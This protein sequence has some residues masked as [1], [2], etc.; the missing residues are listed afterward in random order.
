[1]KIEDEI[2]IDQYGQYL[3]DESE[4]LVRFDKLTEVQKEEYLLE[5]IELILQSKLKDSDIATAIES[6]QLRSTYTSC[7]LLVRNGIKY[8][9]LKRIADLPLFEQPKSLKL[10]LNLFRIAYQRRFEEEKE[11]GNKWWYSDLSDEKNVELIRKQY[12]R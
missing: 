7:V 11:Q 3:I 5:L 6:S 12:E 9:N 2:L 1:M 10:F 8:H 4:I